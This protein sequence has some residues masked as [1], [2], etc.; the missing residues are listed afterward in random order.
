MALALALGLTA[1]A[2]GTSAAWLGWLLGCAFPLGAAALFPT[3]VGADALFPTGVGAAALGVVALQGAT[4]GMDASGR[5]LLLCGA[6][7][8]C[9]LA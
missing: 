6:L 8:P 5:V 2:V 1:A 4:A 3:G 9:D 7:G